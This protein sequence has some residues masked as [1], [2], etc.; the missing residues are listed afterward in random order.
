[1]PTYAQALPQ[2]GN[3]YGRA[4]FRIAI[5]A[6]IPRPPEIRHA[7]RVHNLIIQTVCTRC[8]RNYSSA[9]L[10]ARPRDF[11]HYIDEITAEHNTGRC[12]R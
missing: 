4:H 10:I 2:P 1:M 8:N 7:T 12:I 6:E 3:I 11:V 5:V 9:T